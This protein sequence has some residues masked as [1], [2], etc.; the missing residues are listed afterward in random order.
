MGVAL[1]DALV[2]EGAEVLAFVDVAQRRIGGEKRGKP[3]IA[4]EEVSAGAPALYLGALGQPAARVKLQALFDEKQ[5][6][7]WRDYLMCA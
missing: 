7:V 3:V 4:Y 1:H 2:K 5:M 6:L